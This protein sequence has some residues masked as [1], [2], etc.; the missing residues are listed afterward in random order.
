MTLD[1][2]QRWS[3]CSAENTLHVKGIKE[4]PGPRLVTK[5]TELSPFTERYF[6]TLYRGSEVGDNCQSVVV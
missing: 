2:P 3:G 4:C 5:S 6:V 1:V